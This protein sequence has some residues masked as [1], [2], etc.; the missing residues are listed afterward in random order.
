MANTN[1]TT[2]NFDMT[3]SLYIPLVDT[4]SLPRGNRHDEAAYES[5][6]ADFIGKQ[7]RYQRIGQVNRVDLL[8]KQNPAGFDYFVA[9]VHFDTWYDNPQARSLQSQIQTPGTKAKLQWHERWYW[10]VNEN[11]TPLTAT[12]AELHKAIY[13]QAK[14]AGL[15]EE[16]VQ[17]LQVMKNVD[18]SI[19]VPALIRTASIGF[20]TAWNERLAP[21]V[22]TR[23]ECVMP[24]MTFDNF[25]T[26]TQ[27]GPLHLP[28]T[29]ELEE[30]EISLSPLPLTRSF[31]EGSPLPLFETPTN[32]IAGPPSTPDAPLRPVRTRRLTPRD[33]FGASAPQQWPYT[34]SNL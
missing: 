22:L 16:A 4:R 23:S 33:L 11:K 21:P 30:G 15:T 25:P 26:I 34:A 32:A 17:Y 9:F 2:N 7:F 14:D 3:M 19:S 28:P 5:M 13:T 6:A 29:P 27:D 10:I 8:K 12:E 1:T 31:A 18:A 20:S 24:Q